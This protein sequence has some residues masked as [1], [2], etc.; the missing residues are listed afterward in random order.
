MRGIVEGIDVNIAECSEDAHRTMITNAL[1]A[2]DGAMAV[3]QRIL[4]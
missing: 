3:N 2:A 4:A 1:E